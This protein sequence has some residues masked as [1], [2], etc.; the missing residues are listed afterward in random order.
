MDQKQ[1]SVI[2]KE[3]R[4]GASRIL[5]RTDLMGHRTDVA[6]ISVTI[7]YDLPTNCDNY[8]RR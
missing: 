6:Q 7:N 1:H 8:V 5:I 4:T 3:F 2:M